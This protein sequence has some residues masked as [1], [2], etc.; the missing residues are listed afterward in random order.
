MET[1]PKV[2]SIKPSILSR[3]K[4]CIIPVVALPLFACEGQI[5]D[6]QTQDNRAEE[7]VEIVY[8]L[9]QSEKY[10]IVPPGTQLW[11][12]T[13]GGWQVISNN[14]IV[15]TFDNYDDCVSAIN[16]EIVVNLLPSSDRRLN[17]VALQFAE[18]NADGN[19]RQ[20]RL[21]LTCE[22]I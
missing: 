7:S 22:R 9:L 15:S 10:R 4:Y 21:Q 18:P 16:R 13:I 5:L 20:H 1:P 8:T 19:Y 14:I 2:I 3:L 11:D 6:S 17:Q 12:E